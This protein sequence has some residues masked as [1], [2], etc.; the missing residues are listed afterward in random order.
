MQIIF[1]I[2]KLLKS[3]D[4]DSDPGSGVFFTP[5]SEIGKK[6]R[7]RDEHP[8]IIFPRAWKQFFWLKILNFLDADPDPGSFGPGSGINIPDPQH[9]L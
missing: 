5:E 6:I 3:S 4:A 1:L 9:C 2:E 7:I 8:K